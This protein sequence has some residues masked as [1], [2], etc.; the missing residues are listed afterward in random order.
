MSCQSTD[1]G[2][3]SQVLFFFSK[4]CERLTFGDTKRNNRLYVRDTVARTRWGVGTTRGITAAA[5]SPGAPHPGH[6]ATLGGPGVRLSQPE[7]RARNGD[8][9]AVQLAP[10]CVSLLARQRRTV[11]TCHPNQLA[12]PISQRE[13]RALAR[14]AA[15][16]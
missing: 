4:S 11:S 16:A 7:V 9:G 10:V 12:S 8:A 6:H 2:E 13:I 15:H 3:L 14:R 5:H 1:L